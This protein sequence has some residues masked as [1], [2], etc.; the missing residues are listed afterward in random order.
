MSNPT[1]P[2]C[3]E[4]VIRSHSCSTPCQRSHRVWILVATILGS[5]MAFI[6]ST[7][8]N[9]ALP[10][11]QTQ[12]NATVSDVQWVVESYALFVAAL[13][14]VGGSLGDHLGR[15]RVFMG[16]VV[17]FAIASLWCGLSS[18]VGQL[19]LA[20]GIQG[21]GAALLIPGSLAIIGASFPNEQRGAAIGFW[22]G[23]T[24]ITSAAGP[25][26]GGWLI[27]TFSWRWVFLINLPLAAIVIVISRWCVPESRDPQA[28][29][30]DWLGAAL[31]I[32]GLGGVVY[33]LLEFPK[34]G[35]DAIVIGA[36][37]SG[38]LILGGFLWLESRLISP[39]LPLSLFRSR[40][41][42]G[43][44]LLTLLLY[45]ALGGA[46]FFLPFNLIQ[47]Q[48]YSATAAGAALVPFPLIMF[49]LSRW[50]GGLVS[51]YGAR[52]PLMMG[53][54][55][56]AIGFGLMT[57]PGIGGSYWTTFFP[58][59]VV[60]GLGMAI[61]VAPLTTAVMN[62][63]SERFVGAASGV[64]NAVS[65]IASLLAIALF[66]IVMLN[67]FNESLNGRI[68]ALPLSPTA[69]QFLDAQRINLAAATLPPGLDNGVET[70]LR[71]A[72]AESFVDGFRMVMGIAAGLAIAS[73]ITAMFMIERRRVKA[74][75]S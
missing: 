36:I 9:V 48:S 17:L 3:D 11:L 37:A 40:T 1:K 73:A 44:N 46:L 55:I 50:S 68:A 16:G 52:L 25:V 49:F 63:V 43:A 32:T 56:A 15:R 4:G 62:A 71:S 6:D 29:K 24:A 66:G 47:V 45:A 19:I 26:L 70:A 31:A 27:E 23:F 67:Q 58:A 42:S 35:F 65:R 2:P 13:I 74:N 10:T 33:G 53:P 72:I 21:I 61:C 8:V 7:V 57:L 41:F 20:R 12:L 59:V 60:L 54:T 5:S 18:T 28:A 64:N 22:S 34:L 38:I 75:R 30:L 14:L 39:M 51:R 69:Q